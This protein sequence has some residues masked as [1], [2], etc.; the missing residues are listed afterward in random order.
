MNQ[1]NNIILVL[2]ILAVTL[3]GSVAEGASTDEADPIKVG[4][5]LPLSGKMAEIGEM[6]LHACEMAA[7]RINDSGGID[8]RPIALKIK[9]S[10][11]PYE[12]G[13][14]AM[15]AL[16]SA[17]EVVGVVGGCASTTT[18]RAAAVAQE[19]KTPFL[20]TTASADK[21]TTQGWSCI[22]RLTPPV[23][24]HFRV[25]GTF[26]KQAASVKTAAVVYEHGPF[27]RFGRERFEQLRHVAG[28]KLVRQDR[29]RQGQYNFQKIFTQIKARHPDLVYLIASGP[30]AP[31]FLMRSAERAGLSPRLFLGH[32][33]GFM[34][35]VFPQYAGPAAEGLFSSTLWVPSVPYPGADAFAAGYTDKYGSPPDYHGA[36][37]YA[38]L[39]VIADALKRA[40]SIT[41]DDL[42][43]ALPM[44]DMIT[45][46]GPVRFED[47]GEK[48]R[49][50]RR[51]KL[52]VQW[53]S[54]RLEVVWPRRCASVPDHFTGR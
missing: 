53:I 41:R 46:F 49:Q 40:E 52:V 14:T 5:L 11:G 50:N 34:D 28:I 42:R 18:F 1:L 6:Q 51:P 45:V 2:L 26:L 7:D 12:R 54:G 32:G 25:L 23:S 8:G 48:T 13:A 9:D 35:A 29:F 38:A 33:K 43:D 21:L 17:P 22:F 39:S 15:K 10:G 27:G 19:R 44:T 20:I 24:E 31:A 36:Q 3:T 47:Y 4:L 30:A 37:G 16:T